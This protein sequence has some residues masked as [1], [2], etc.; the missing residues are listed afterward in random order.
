MN[1]LILMCTIFCIYYSGIRSVFLR[2]ASL[3]KLFF[4]HEMR[5]F[6]SLFIICIEY[7]FNI[8]L[9]QKRNKPHECLFVKK[10]M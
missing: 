2:A 10:Y 1:L 5:K 6:N 9:E 8:K 4:V 7:I 3:R